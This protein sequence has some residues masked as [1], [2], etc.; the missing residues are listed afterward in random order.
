MDKRIVKSK[1]A[2]KKALIELSREKP[3]TEISIRDL[4]REAGISRSTFYNNY[5]LF[6]DVIVE[7]SN[8][9]M[10]K[11]EGKRLSREFLDFMIANSDEL[12][13]LLESGIFGKR[14]AFYLKELI[15]EDLQLDSKD[16]EK[17]LELNVLTLYHS[18]GL[19]GCLLNMIENANS[20]DYE[21][22]HKVGT[23]IL[24]KI[25]EDFSGYVK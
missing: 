3:Y 19:F 20:P 25:I 1:E 8:D 18:Y 24:S 14:F 22:I 17:D 21:Y 13:V 11:I 15:S 2:I 6:N 16:G 10:K 4:C 7:M 5:K 23:D 12:K 9:F